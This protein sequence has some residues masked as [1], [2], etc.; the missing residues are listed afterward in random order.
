MT[1]LWRSD[2]DLAKPS[3]TNASST[4]ATEITIPLGN[5][6]I[7]ITQCTRSALWSS[8]VNI[9]TLDTRPKTHHL[10][11]AAQNKKHGRRLWHSDV[12][13]SPTAR[14]PTVYVAFWTEK[15]NIL[16][17]QCFYRNNKMFCGTK[18][19]N[20]CSNAVFRHWHSPTIV[21]P[22]VYCPAD[23]AL[24]EISAE[25][26]CSGRQVATVVTETTQLVLSQFK[27]C[28]L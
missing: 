8:T 2:L 15:K 23:D 13:V 27:N 7:S 4:P 18:S 16:N 28:L 14:H 22:L 11:I 9:T 24:F 12:L 21:F 1:R 17:R 5:H 6:L 20:T 26:C 10:Q 25:I 3:T 19:Y